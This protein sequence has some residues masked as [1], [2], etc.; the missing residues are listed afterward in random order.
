MVLRLAF[1][2]RVGCT[3]WLEVSSKITVLRLKKKLCEHVLL[4]GLEPTQIEIKLL[5]WPLSDAL[6]LQEYA[7]Y[8]G[9]PLHGPLGRR[10]L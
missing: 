7:L 1:S 4:R 8:H 10:L 2:E 5:G 3:F 6:R 9:A